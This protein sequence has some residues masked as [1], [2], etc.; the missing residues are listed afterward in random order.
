MSI[1]YPR[2]DM[3]DLNGEG[4]KYEGIGQAHTKKK[5]KNMKKKMVEWFVLQYTS[6]FYKDMAINVT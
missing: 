5:G 2:A 4:Y 1:E 6:S 3:I